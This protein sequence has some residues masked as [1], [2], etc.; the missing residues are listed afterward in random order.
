VLVSE[1]WQPSNVSHDIQPGLPLHVLDGA[2]LDDLE[3]LLGGGYGPGARY[4]P[5]GANPIDWPF[6]PALAVPAALLNS[7][8]DRALLLCDPEGTPLARFVITE[9]MPAEAGLVWVGGT[10]EQT[11]SPEHGPFRRLRR[12]ADEMR[13][14]NHGKAV[15]A[16]MFRGVP[17]DAQLAELKE[18]TATADANPL[19][20][21]L[22]GTGTPRHVD[23]AGLVRAVLFAAREFANAQMIA[24]P[25]PAQDGL[26]EQAAAQLRHH[27]A[28]AYGATT[29][30]DVKPDTAPSAPRLPAA[31]AAELNRRQ[32]G[33]VVLFTGLSGSGKSTIAR[34]LVDALTEPNAR[35]VTLLDGDQVRRM[36]SAGLGF[37]RADRELNVRRI[38]FV[39]SL[40]ARH[41]GIAVCA[42]IAPY[43]SVRAEVRAMAEAAGTFV[44]VYVA[45]PLEV[46][47]ARDRKGLYAQA[48]AGLIPQFTGVSDP[49]EEPADADVVVDG[50]ATPVDT[51]VKAV[52]DR[53]TV[54]GVR[55]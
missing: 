9:H 24:I 46:C 44:L 51:A 25:L 7:V 19:L 18:H 43:A 15:V 14:G 17:T 50:S 48:R 11:R 22:I 2:A 47:E 30:I 34:A 53:L 31:S 16:A 20:V 4:S 52:L 8:G 35:E 27:V 32:D 55:Y 26:D 45:T 41:G 28:R 5:P 23:S 40:I 29:V 42:P 21:A 39:A 36:L 1:V 37:S 38:G 12:T 33:A 10:A 3:M 49:Y 54:L 13:A 6:H